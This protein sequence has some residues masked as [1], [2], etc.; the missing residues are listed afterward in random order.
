MFSRFLFIGLGGSG[1]KTLRFI[2]RDL[3][4]LME[5]HGIENPEIPDAWQFLN[6]D[7]PTNPDGKELNSIVAPLDVNEYAGLISQGTE[8][9]SLQKVLDQR[10]KLHPEMHGWRVNPAAVDVSISHGAG[11]FRAVG[12]SVA[13]YNASK[14]HREID[15]RLSKLNKYDIA[16]LHE[17]EEAITGVSPDG[18][19]K[20]G[21]HVFVISSLAG[22]S[23]AGML[24]EVCDIIRAIKPAIGQELFG[25]LYTP[26][27]FESLGP[28]VT[29]GV[30]ANAL[31]AISEILN[32]YWYGGDNNIMSDAS[33][34]PPISDAV[35]E[36]VGLSNS[37]VNSG[38]AYPF[39]I[40]RVNQ[41]GIDHGRPERL[42]EIVAKSLSSMLTS[43]AAYSKFVA[44]V[45]G[46]WQQYKDDRHSA[47]ESD[48]LV[49]RGRKEEQGHPVFSSFG[50]ARLSVGLDYFEE[51]TIQR[52]LK[53]NYAHL[54]R[55]HYESPE[56]KVIA[57]DKDEKNPDIIAEEIAKLHE[58]RFKDLAGLNEITDKFNQVQDALIPD[59]MQELLDGFTSNVTGDVSGRIKKKIE[60]AEA[61]NIC[62]NAIEFHK[63][64]LQEKMDQLIATEVK[65]W[66]ENIGDSILN[67][68]EYTIAQI[69]LRAT[70]EVCKLV[71]NELEGELQTELDD[72]A[73][74]HARIASKFSNELEHITDQ[75]GRLEP[76]SRIIY[77]SLEEAC[78]S[79]WA[80]AD[81][82]LAENSQMLCREISKRY[83][84]PLQKAISRSLE[85]ATN[86]YDEM[87]EFVNWSDAPPPSSVTPHSGEY[88]LIKPNEFPKIFKSLLVDTVGVTRNNKESLRKNVIEPAILANYLHRPNIKRIEDMLEIKGPLTERDTEKLELHTIKQTNN[89]WYPDIAGSVRPAQNVTL[90]IAISMDETRARIQNW[91]QRE[92]SSFGSFLET[93]LRSYLG[94]EDTFQN[95]TLS[96][97]ELSTRRSR[98]VSQFNAATKSS[99]PLVNIGTG[100][101]GAVHPADKPDPEELFNYAYS[102]IPLGSH[103][104]TNKVE[105]ILD[106][107]GL[108][109]G[110]INKTLNNDESIEH[111][112]IT[113][114]IEKPCSPMVFDSIF[115]PISDKRQKAI[116][117]GAGSLQEFWRN[118]RTKPIG[119][120]IPAPQ[121]TILAMIRGWLTCRMLGLITPPNFKKDIPAKIVDWESGRPIE[122][123]HPLLDPTP[124]QKDILT[125]ILESLPL[126]YAEVNL[127]GN[128]D[129][130]DP[131]ISLR[132]FGSPEEAD[133][134]ES[135]WSYA[136]IN[137][138]L[139]DWIK[140]G[141]LP[142][143]IG[144][145]HNDLILKTED[146]VT[147][148]ARIKLIHKFLENRKSSYGKDF[149]EY[150]RDAREQPK[151]LSYPPYWVGLNSLYMRAISDLDKAVADAADNLYSE[152]W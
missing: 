112:D 95:E 65:N 48:V 71:A 72:E 127:T 59:S 75:N 2:K 44:Y 23:G 45:I 106:H 20:P 28:G 94:V 88:T 46:N 40:G 78:N 149:K 116:S 84:R 74:I 11:Q 29:G 138:R 53:A 21:L 126:A 51:Y 60:A 86:E 63:D 9:E 79:V 142:D 122:F 38:P 31:A 93:G 4:A 143:A 104:L 17:I 89:G 26:E 105:A 54:T 80:Y 10:R 32:G 150:V 50:Y 13:M 41:Q 146:E 111:I 6:F 102:E 16:Q 114:F 83:I 8:L 25:I 125:A 35:I 117:G 43:P 136:S 96:D 144:K 133:L 12:R 39:L 124:R 129:S 101:F 42:F 73:K 33:S 121:P 110:E 99:A 141:E 19:E 22:G 147:P 66:I 3:L 120:F 139:L 64:P 36:S 109:D 24:L 100:A 68:A 56:A 103:D 52:I 98:F 30:Q 82:K 55:Y 91:L 140:T 57:K 15:E 137:S 123:P 87:D 119:R 131:Y 62:K 5:K 148:E 135:I 151:T 69:G 76:N 85:V 14:I 47:T 90:E 70:A 118:R 49:N 34:V 37:I 132:S 58:S 145:P 81:Q 67:A 108:D 61:F 27:V 128:L 77:D 97:N 7:T 130:L 113:T 134:E 107:N 92:G 18:A 115:R 1:G 152:D